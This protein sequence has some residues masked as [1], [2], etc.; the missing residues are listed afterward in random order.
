[1]TLKLMSFRPDMHRL[2]ALAARERLLP[3]G[4]DLGYA[5]HAVFAAS[6]ADRAPK[7]FRFLAPGDPG[8][9]PAGR[10]FAYSACSLDD[11][12]AQATAF[13]DPAF[14]N[15]LRLEEAEAKAMPTDFPT[16]TRL[17]FSLRLRPVQRTGASPDGLEKARERD[18]YDGPGEGEARGAAARAHAYAAWLERQFNRSNAATLEDW[19][20]EALKQTRLRAR[21]R[22]AGTSTPR[23]VSGPDATYS[24]VLRVTDPEAFAALLA[25]GIGRF[26]AF[27]FG[28]LLLKPPG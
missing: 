17:G 5:L 14:A 20:I 26:R 22:G 18:V 28:M 16:G 8:G 25:R 23:D 10:L 7:P 11:L 13:A 1:M 9:G 6:F 21:D 2:L 3:A 15:V 19:H 12:R 24:G 4:G 27:G